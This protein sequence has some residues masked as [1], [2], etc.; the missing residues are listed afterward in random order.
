MKKSFVL[1]LMLLFA[2]AQAA[3][4]FV[5][6]VSYVT[7]GDTLWVQAD[8][9]GAPLKLRLTGLDAPEICQAGGAA[10][11]AALMALTLQQRVRVTVKRK[12]M[13]GRGLAQLQ[14]GGLD[15]SAEMVRQGQAWSYRWRQNLGPYAAEEA[16]A[17][18][19]RRGLFAQPY[20]ENPRN[21]RKRHG[22]C[23][24]NRRSIRG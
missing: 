17:R 23:Y 16:G 18:E 1:L 22:S 20:P 8:R 9:G 12:D 2:Q 3:Y 15:V 4:V 21:F 19:A 11:K 6:R 13:Y 5:G 24:K 10:A 7:D 14:L